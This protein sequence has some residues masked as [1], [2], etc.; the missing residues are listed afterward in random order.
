MTRCI[1]QIYCRALSQNLFVFH[2]KSG[3]SESQ[4]LFYWRIFAKFSPE[5]YDFDLQK[6][7]FL[8][9]KSPN[10]PDFE[11]K[12]SKSPDIYDKF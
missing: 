1:E 11:E 7:F 10:S 12:V 2:L 9:R 4:R 8:E 6:R 5:K 3:T